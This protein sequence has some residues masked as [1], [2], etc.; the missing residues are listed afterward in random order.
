MPAG[1][2]WFAE[3]QPFTPV[4]ETLRGLLLGTPIG[5]SAVTAAAW[6]AG[7]ALAGY[8][9]SRRLFNRDPA[10]PPTGPAPASRPRGWPP[11]Q[12]LLIPPRNAPGGAADRRAHC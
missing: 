5:S 4:I 1:V 10:P 2:R 11:E 12:R 8:L 6:C 9:W 3:H 7:L